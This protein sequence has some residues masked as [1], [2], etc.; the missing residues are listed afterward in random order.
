MTYGEAMDV[1]FREGVARSDE[2]LG[3]CGIERAQSEPCCRRLAHEERDE[4]GE[5]MPPVDVLTPIGGDEEERHL[6]DPVRDEAQQVERGAV[7]PMEVFEHEYE[8]SLRRQ[9]NEEVARL[10]EE[11]RLARRTVEA[12]DGRRGGGVRMGFNTPGDLDP[13]TVGWG[14][15]AV[16]TVAGEDARARVRRLATE[17]I[18]EGRLPDAGLAADQDEAAPTITRRRQALVQERQLAVAADQGRRWCRR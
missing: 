13:G 14:F 5:R 3:G 4:R 1:R 6:V 15:G 10:C 18:C 7:R 12:R 2:R 17:C 9:G 11:V 8:R 16:I